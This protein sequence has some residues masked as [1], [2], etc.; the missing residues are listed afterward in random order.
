[1]VTWKEPMKG[2]SFSQVRQTYPQ[3]QKRVY[4]VLFRLT[5]RQLTFELAQV[6]GN[7][8]FSK[9]MVDQPTFEVISG[10]MTALLEERNLLFTKDDLVVCWQRFNELIFAYEAVRQGIMTEK[11]EGGEIIYEVDSAPISVGFVPQTRFSVKTRQSYQ[12]K[13]HRDSGKL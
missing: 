7:K 1:M 6:Q 13:V 9:V 11:I 2:F 3:L 10:V 4:D 5:P 12:S 8:I